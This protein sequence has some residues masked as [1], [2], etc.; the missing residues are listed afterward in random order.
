MLKT[1]HIPLFCVIV[2]FISWWEGRSPLKGKNTVFIYYVWYEIKYCR[3]FPATFKQAAKL[4]NPLAW[5]ESGTYAFYMY[6][7]M[8]AVFVNPRLTLK[9]Y[10][11]HV[12]VLT[13]MRRCRSVSSFP[14]LRKLFKIINK[15]AESLSIIGPRP[16][17]TNILFF[18][19]LWMTLDLL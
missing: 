12:N 17:Q 10:S 6:V 13:W 5:S 9:T 3:N 18:N 15:A 1:F 2:I 11:Y 7:Y 14:Y 4:G 8:W 16:A 19:K